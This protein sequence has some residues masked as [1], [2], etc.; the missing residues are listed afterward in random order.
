MLHLNEFPTFFEELW[1]YPPFPWQSR[2][3]QEV[4]QDKWPSILDLPTGAG[5]TA[6]LDIACFALALEANKEASQRKQCRRIALIV[7]RRIIVD[8]AYERAKQICDRLASASSGVLEKT[9]KALRSLHSGLGSEL[10]MTVA[11]L[12]GGTVRDD[13]WARAPDQ[14]CFLVSTVDQVGSRILFRGYGVSSSMAPI[15]AG[16]LGVDCLY[17]LDE[18]HLSRPFAQTLARIVEYNNGELFEDLPLRAAS[19][20][21]MSATVG[22]CDDAFGLDDEDRGHQVLRKRLSARKQTQ[23]IEPIPVKAN[24]SAANE[25]IAKACVR[26]ALAHIEAGSRATAIIV[27]RV[28]TARYAASIAK[29]KL[30]HVVLLTGRMR[31]IDRDTIQKSISPDVAAGRVRKNS[32]PILVISTQ[33][34]EAG[35]DYDFDAI[36][37]EC[38]SLDA[39]RQRFGRLDRQGTL[40]N[41]SRASIVVSARD[42]AEGADDPIYGEAIYHAWR[43][44]Q[45]HAEGSLVDMGIDAQNRRETPPEK[46]LAPRKSAP[47]LLPAY[48]DLWAQTAPKPAVEPDV[49]PFLHGAEQGAPQVQVLWRADIE[50]AL[51]DLAC[52]SAQENRSENSQ[53]AANTITAILEACPP[54]ALET[55]TLPIW[56]ARAWLA[57]DI[58]EDKNTPK[59]DR[60]AEI[61]GLPDVEGSRN[62]STQ[63]SLGSASTP[64]VVY[65]HDKSS[66]SRSLSEILPGS[67]LVLPSSFGGLDP[68]TK[69]WDPTSTDFVEDLGDLA[70]LLHRGRAVLRWYKKQ[71]QPGVLSAP[72]LDEEELQ[73]LG[74]E[75]L[76][77]TFIEWQAKL[78]RSSVT[79]EWEKFLANWIVESKRWGVIE[80]QLSDALGSLQ[81]QNPNWRASICSRRIP[82]EIL[83]NLFGDSWSLT[84]A[85]AP[86]QDQSSF[87]SVAVPLKVHLQGVEGVAKSFAKHLS[88]PQALEE[89]LALAGL[90]H[91]LGK[92]DPR[93]QVMLKGGDLVDA[94][95]ATHLLA[96]SAL[97]FFDLAQRQRAR[98]R[99][100]YPRG[101]RHELL[102]VALVQ[103]NES[104][105]SRA[106][107]WDLV[108]HLVA[109]HH[110]HCRPFAPVVEDDSDLQVEVTLQGDLFS[111]SS[112]HQLDSLSSGVS[113]RFWR[114]NSSMGWHALAYLEAILR[115]AD[116]RRSE[117]EQTGDTSAH[118]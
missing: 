55:V 20:V 8:Q 76:R 81:V 100:G 58:S 102:S 25:K 1:G 85:L 110:G 82:K 77:D 28:D 40:E 22:E 113:E 4:S 14:P 29:K 86:S 56:A 24:R 94:S 65:Q 13:N 73:D 87:T 79:P 44:L 115:L 3:M 31:S 61:A 104:V 112:N 114:L 17:L 68:T 38:A 12:R 6:V 53:K 47:E 5:K 106:N 92:S 99:S 33:A 95:C 54:S 90:L 70:Q 75:L 15:H 116:H 74:E 21:S 103:D 117:V 57:S 72:I 88:L 37:S 83:K 36:V 63:T 64:F 62:P 97:P 43:W 23:L 118:D 98:E 9:A 30:D 26:E 93:F 11:S 32:N 66:I 19:M 35:A 67:T 42:I 27:N 39:L 2:L 50:P 16:L 7:D 10:P 59:G 71:T 51:L 34:I 78:Q 80:L 48:F 60:V 69:N 41:N 105:R 46:A 52:V 96:K 91:D 107:R 49:S 45:E 101:G 108:L 18:V 89:D 109:S 84:D 111:A